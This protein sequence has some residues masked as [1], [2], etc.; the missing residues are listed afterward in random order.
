MIAKRVSVSS[1]LAAACFAAAAGFA[2]LASAA[3]LTGSVSTIPPAVV[4]LTTEGTADWAIWDYQT[5]AT[6]T[7]GAPSNRKAGGALIGNMTAALGTPRGITGTATPPNYNY[8]NGTSP[9]SATNVSIG[10]VTDTSVNVLGSGYRLSI[11]G[12]PAVPET[13]IVYTSL[14]NATGTFTATLNGA[15][16]YTNST[17]TSANSVRQAAVYSLTFQPNTAGDLLQISYTVNSLNTGGNSNLDL[18]A[19]TVA[20]PEPGSA[21]LLCAGGLVLLR[22]R[23]RR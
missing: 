6:G 13:V 15:T 2:G 5:S 12:T 16:T 4:N 7:S 1:V 11:T 9:V 17:P 18:Q 21:A 22:R 19:V 14:F 20:V 3:T 10:A 8:T 23:S